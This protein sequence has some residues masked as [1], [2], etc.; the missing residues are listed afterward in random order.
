MEI[1]GGFRVAFYY[2]RKRVGITS[3]CG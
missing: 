3:T 2:E 1:L